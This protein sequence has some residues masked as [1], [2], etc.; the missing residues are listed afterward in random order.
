MDA[1]EAPGEGK[2]SVAG[3]GPVGHGAEGVV[4]CINDAIT[5]GHRPRVD[6]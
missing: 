3:D 2:T 1:K 6:A 5:C 4:L